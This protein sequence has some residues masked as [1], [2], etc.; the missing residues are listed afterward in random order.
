MTRR[1]WLWITGAASAVLLL[2]LALIDREL[3]ST[4][5]PGI[6]PFEIAGSTDRANE[7]LADWGEEGRDRA[8]LSLW[9]DFPYLVFYAAFF[10]L[11]LA[12]MRDAAGNRG[13]TRYA[14]VA[15]IAVFAPIAAA[16]FD[17]VEDV[18]LLLVVGGHSDSAA[19]AIAMTFAIAKFVAL[20]VAQLCLLAGLAALG[21][22]RLR[23]RRSANV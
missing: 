22:E 2:V 7:I 20:G 14:K 10:A 9:L 11:A 17:A 21:R 1:R 4:G 15:S 3:A 6:V 19:P 12:A 23:G 5:G 8:R 13:W 16:A 18:N